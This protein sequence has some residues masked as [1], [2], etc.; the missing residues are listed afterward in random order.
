M[1]RS[2]EA[3]ALR[4][5]REAVA[6]AVKH[7]EASRIDIDVEFD[8]ALLVLRI[9]DDG[10][11][12]TEELR[13]AAIRSGHFGVRGM[14]DRARQAGGTCEVVPEA[15]GGTVVTLQLPLG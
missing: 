14:Q 1:P 7:A 6:N 13:E 3:A 2:I 15:E 12:F 4:V 9:R 10:R 11:G 8:A 5:G